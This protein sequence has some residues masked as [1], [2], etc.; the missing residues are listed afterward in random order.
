MII[1]LTNTVLLNGKDPGRIQE[2]AS[3]RTMATGLEQPSSRTSKVVV[4]TIQFDVVVLYHLLTQL[5]LSS[6]ACYN[7]ISIITLCCHVC[8]L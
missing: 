2:H 7:P 8:L 3:Q 5:P 1:K 4:P 6:L